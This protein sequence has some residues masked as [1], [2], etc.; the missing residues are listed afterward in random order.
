M[1]IKSTFFALLL[2]TTIFQSCEEVDDTNISSEFDRRTLLRSVADG[3]ITP[4]LSN[5][6]SSVDNFSSQFNNF[7]SASNKD[8]SSL[9]NQWKVVAENFMDIYSFNFG[10]FAE[11]GINRSFT[12][13]VGTFPIATQKIEDAIA[14]GTY[15]FTDFNRDARGIYAIEYLIFSKSDE[16]V[17]GNAKYLDYLEGALQNLS[18][19]LATYQTSWESYKT[20][21][22]ED[23]STNAG[24]SI[25]L[26]YNEYVKSF[27]NLKN[28]KVQLPLGLRPGQEK[29]EPNNVEALFSGHTLT[30]YQKH[31]TAVKNIWYGIQLDGSQGTGFKQY[32]STVEGG[33]AL[34]SST[35]NS[36]NALEMAVNKIPTSSTF[37]VLVE[38]NNAEVQ[39]WNNLLTQHTRFLKSDLSSLLGIYITF[40]SGDGD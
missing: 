39:E 11:A 28:F 17:N 33:D 5:F 36:W 40:A 35:E 4:G 21:F 26:L 37:K 18:T 25:S 7:K 34:I 27:E 20:S 32:L 19:R 12:E 9:Q 8:I 38:N 1:N 23:N 24:S 14:S 29:A 13:E 15:N 22:V 6:I 10:P 16:L 3:T 2:I 31:Q 30:L